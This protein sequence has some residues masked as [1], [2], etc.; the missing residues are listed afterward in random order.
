M[1]GLHFIGEIS[2]LQ[3]DTSHA[4]VEEESR[5]LVNAKPASPGPQD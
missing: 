3:W 5:C 1:V 4:S 2:R